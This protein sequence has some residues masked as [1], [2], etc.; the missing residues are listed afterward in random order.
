VRV[1]STDTDA[2]KGIANVAFLNEADGTLVLIVVNTHATPRTISVA[3][4][5]T[6]FEYAMPG[7]SVGTFVWYPDRA[8]SLIRQAFRWLKGG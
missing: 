6:R 4:G 2:E 1:K 5:Q 7:R 3:E 8:G